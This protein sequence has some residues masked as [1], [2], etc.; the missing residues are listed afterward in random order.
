MN[1]DDSNKSVRWLHL[2]DF[3]IKSGDSYDRDVVLRALQNS[4]PTLLD[5]AGRPDV[6]FVS[7]DLAFSGLKIE[8]DRVSLIFDEILPCN[9]KLQIIT[10][11]IFKGL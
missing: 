1:I 4:I 5:R 9:S 3:H 8:Y 2:S 7:G 10:S 6:L 11:G